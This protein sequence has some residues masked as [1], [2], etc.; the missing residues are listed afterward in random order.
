MIKEIQHIAEAREVLGYLYENGI[1][2]EK[3]LDQ[4][5]PKSYGRQEFSEKCNTV[6]QHVFDNYYGEYQ[7]SKIKWRTVVPSGDNYEREDET[8]N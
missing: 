8:N 3:D 7:Q 6:F 1:L 5:L 2:V 4:G